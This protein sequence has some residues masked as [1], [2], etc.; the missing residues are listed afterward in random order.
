M[1]IYAPLGYLTTPAQ[2]RGSGDACWC[3]NRRTMLT[4]GIRDDVTI[5]VIFF[6]Y[7]EH[8]TRDLKLIGDDPNSSDTLDLA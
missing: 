5:Q 4:Q 2:G 8:R 1:S 6:G 7:G 3:T